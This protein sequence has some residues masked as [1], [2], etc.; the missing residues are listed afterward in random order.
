MPNITDHILQAQHNEDFYRA[1]DKNAYS[2]WAMTAVYYAALHYVDA[3][4]ARAGMIDPGG[5]DVR[6]REMHMRMELRPIVK[7][8]F[9]LKS[10]SRSVRYYCT[11]FSFPELQRSYEDDLTEIRRHLLPLASSK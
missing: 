1:T 8:Y 2:D 9:R 4:L 7:N 6:D 11:T 10:R 5:H 3:F